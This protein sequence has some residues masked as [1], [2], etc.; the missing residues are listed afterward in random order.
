MTELSE[1]RSR[2]IGRYAGQPEMLT[3]LAERMSDERLRAELEPGGWSTHQ[4]LTHI[5]DVE[6]QAFVPRL[7]KILEEDSPKLS[8]FD[9]EVWMD[10]HYN[11][12]E[13]VGDILREI[14]ALRSKGSSL[15]QPLGHDGWSRIGEHP[16]FGSRTLQ[17][18]IEYA[19]SHFD[20]HL[21]QLVKADQK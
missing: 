16:S 6:A 20:E 1:Y 2:L 8:S 3:A 4:V 15:I 19:V 13:P 5:R 11:A 21:E 14:E 17:W 12:Q 9:P 7:S 10:G 18:W